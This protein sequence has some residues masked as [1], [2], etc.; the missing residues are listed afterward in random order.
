M[1]ITILAMITHTFV[2]ADLTTITLNTLTASAGMFTNASTT[3][4]FASVTCSTM[5][6]FPAFITCS[7]TGLAINA[8]FQ[9]QPVAVGFEVFFAV[10]LLACS[11]LDEFAKVRHYRSLIY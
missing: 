2:F 1:Q 10:F 4:L 9:E 8:T 6:T 11:A 7:L 3:T 5:L